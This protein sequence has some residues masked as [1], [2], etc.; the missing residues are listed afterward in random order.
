ML[1]GVV[2]FLENRRLTW[3]NTPFSVSTS[4]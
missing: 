2:A 4:V 1:A 3:A